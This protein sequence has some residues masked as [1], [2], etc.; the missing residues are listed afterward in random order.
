MMTHAVHPQRPLRPTD[1]V[2]LLLAAWL[3]VTIPAV[4]V[5]APDTAPVLIWA[6]GGL[7]CVL[8]GID[9]PRRLLALAHS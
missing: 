7:G 1:L 3:L 5:Y 9:L 2:R 6:Q 4:L 8:L